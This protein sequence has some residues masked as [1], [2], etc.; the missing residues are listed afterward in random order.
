MSVDLR[1]DMH[2]IDKAVDDL[3]RLRKQALPYAARDAMNTSAFV[4]RRAWSTMIERTFTTRNA[5]TAKTSL[6]VDKARGTNLSSMH[7][8]LG[9]TADYMGL[10]ERGGTVSG[11]I[12]GPAAARQAPG[13]KR[14]APVKIPVRSVKVDRHRG[15]TRAQRNAIAIAMAKRRGAKHVLIDRPGGGKGLFALGGGKKQAKLKLLWAVKR[16]GAFLRPHPT[17]GPTLR[18]LTKTFE[19]IH[20]QAVAKQLKMHRIGS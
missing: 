10:Q 12:P 9:S 8:I 6:R 13:G 17:L 4:A 20:S 11:P 15:R 18:T 7:A 14:T 3:Q 2:G 1:V 5:F 19:V 16:G